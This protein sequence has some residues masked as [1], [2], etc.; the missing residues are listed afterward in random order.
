MREGVKMPERLAIIGLGLMGGSLAMAIRRNRFALEVS[1]WGRRAESRAQ[2]REMQLADSVPETIEET[3]ADADLVVLCVPVCSTPAVLQQLR[4]FLREGAVITDVGSTKAWVV[5]Q[6]R[7][8]TS[9]PGMFVGSHPVAG[10]QKTGL[11]AARADL[12]ENS[13]CVVTPDAVS[14]PNAVEA[15]SALWQAAGCR[16]VSLSPHEHDLLLARSSHLPHITAAALTR[17]V[18]QD[19]AHSIADFCGNGFR[20]STRIAAGSEL[21]WRDILKTNS[22]ALSAEIERMIAELRSIQNA[23]DARNWDDVA[24]WLSAARQLRDAIDEA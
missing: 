16:V 18:C 15:V 23:L 1:A 6:C 8:L 20:D 7:A 9:T 12:Y 10:S 5:E 2:A 19:G 11:D 4:P 21:L 17:T 13:V 3:V 14:S 22:Q 24:A